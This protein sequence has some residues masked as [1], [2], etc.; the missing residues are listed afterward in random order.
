[1]KRIDANQLKSIGDSPVVMMLEDGSLYSDKK[2]HLKEYTEVFNI[3]D[4]G[5]MLKDGKT[6]LDLAEISAV[7]GASVVLVDRE[8]IYILKTDFKKIVG[9]NAN[10][11]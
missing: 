10:D 3:R 2:K 6:I 7:A 4:G 1:M 11:E 8:S 5:Y 9:R